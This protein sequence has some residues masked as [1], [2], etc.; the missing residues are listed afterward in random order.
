MARILNAAALAPWFYDWNPGDVGDEGQISI[1]STNINKKANI[2]ASVNNIVN[3]RHITFKARPTCV[4]H[5]LNKL[6]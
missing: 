6:L 4:T 2:L 5:L 3:K 1:F